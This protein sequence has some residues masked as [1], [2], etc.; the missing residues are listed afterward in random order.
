MYSIIEL[1]TTAGQTAHIYQTAATR[2]DAMSKFHGILSFASIS[3]VEY[4]TC[5]VLDEEG[6]TIARECYM[7]LKNPNEASEPLEET[8][9]DNTV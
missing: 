3:Q 8:P 5:I 6:R 1:Q 4:H 9:D 7:H 2:D